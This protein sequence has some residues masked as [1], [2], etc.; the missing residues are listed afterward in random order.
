MST[1]VS[2]GLKNGSLTS[3]DLAQA[4]TSAA[5]GF[6]LGFAAQGTTNLLFSASK[7][8]HPSGVAV[9]PLSGN[10]YSSPA[11]IYLDNLFRLATQGGARTYRE[12]ANSVIPNT[13]A[14][15]TQPLVQG[16]FDR[17]VL[18]AAGLRDSRDPYAYIFNRNRGPY[19]RFYWQTLMF[20]LLGNRII[21]KGNLGSCTVAPT[22][23]DCQ[24]RP[25]LPL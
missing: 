4:G 14:S 18:P 24:V 9:I 13:A 23:S 3:D 21:W 5:V 11:S 2:N 6:G 25:K 20:T 19:D 12:T 1:L 22:W 10:R 16:P 17:A 8:H 7:Y 15:I